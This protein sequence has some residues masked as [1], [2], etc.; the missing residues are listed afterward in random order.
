MALFNMTLCSA[1]SAGSWPALR[2]DVFARHQAV[3][4]FKKEFGQENDVGICN[5]DEIGFLWDWEWS[6]HPTG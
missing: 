3:P 4:K 6:P 2:V 5:L 1:V